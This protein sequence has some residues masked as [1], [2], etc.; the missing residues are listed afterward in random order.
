MKEEISTDP[1]NSFR[2]WHSTTEEIMYAIENKLMLNPM[3]DLTNACNLNCPYC[4]IEE[5]NSTRKVRKQSELTLEETLEVITIFHKLGAKTIDLVGAGE[6]TV[7]PHFKEIIQFIESLGMVTSLFTNGIKI[8]KEPEISDFLF[9]NDVSV[10]L[11]LNSFDSSIQDAVAGKKGYGEQMRK[12][13]DILI[14]RGFTSEVPT[15]IAVNTIAFK[16]N[17]AELPVIHRFCR[18]NNIY[19]MTGDFIPTGRTEGQFV[20]NTLLSGM[21]E[22][23]ILYARDLLQPLSFE[24]KIWLR[25]ELKSIDL[26]FSVTHSSCPSYYG[27]GIC[28]QQIGMYVDIEGNIWPCVARGIMQGGK[29]SNGLL[30]N[31]RKGDN[32]IDIWNSHPYLVQIRQ[33]FDGSCPYKTSLK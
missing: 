23:E 19:P 24:E 21:S 1:R 9:S 33:N 28:T 13:L 8:F 11:K 6:P 4:Y 2:G 18:E 32:V 12:A 20:R 16:G 31:I 22:D 26:E 27:G 17:L 5:K 29:I 15:R 10:I 14:A 30:G 25:K 3:L 7:D